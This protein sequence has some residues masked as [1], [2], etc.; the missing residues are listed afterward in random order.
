MGILIGNV[1]SLFAVMVAVSI[2]KNRF[3]S[4]LSSYTGTMINP[5]S[6]TSL[7]GSSTKYGSLIHTPGSFQRVVVPLQWSTF[8]MDIF[9]WTTNNSMMYEKQ[10]F[11]PAKVGLNIGKPTPSFSG[12]RESVWVISEVVKLI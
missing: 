9:A 10:L 8:T 11:L 2:I 7:V 5:S 3:V 1:V 4:I 6:S 12:R